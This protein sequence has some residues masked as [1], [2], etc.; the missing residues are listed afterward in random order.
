MKKGYPLIFV[1]EDNLAYNKIVVHFLKQNCYENILNFS[2][3]EEC[4][5]HMY[6]KPD[7]IVQDYKLQGIS[8]LFVLQR[9]KKILP[10]T[11]FVFLS[12]QESIDIAT[13]TIKHGAFD[14]IVKNDLALHQ[15]IKKIEN[16][17]TL[18]LLRKKY[19]IQ[20]LFLILSLTVII[21][22]AM[23]ILLSAL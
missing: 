4:L 15:L 20:Q 8:G 21:M 10:Y 5:Q 17:K 16:I 19:K 14:Y 9:T 18:Q 13:N 22:I 3:G 11:E 23:G 7:I 12:S 2:S 6:L 1:V